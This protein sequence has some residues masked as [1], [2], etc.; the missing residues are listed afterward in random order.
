MLDVF[1]F[2]KKQLY[3]YDLNDPDYK[4]SADHVV[5]HSREFVDCFCLRWTVVFC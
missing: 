4:T 3:T 2:I 1:N 5:I